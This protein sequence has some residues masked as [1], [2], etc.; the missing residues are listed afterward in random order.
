[1]V[2]YER[3]QCKTLTE[4][5]FGVLERWSPTEGGDLREV[6]AR[7]VRLCSVLG[8]DHEKSLNVLS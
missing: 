8:S 7:G 1:M 5:I 3:F 2:V 6:V 4:N